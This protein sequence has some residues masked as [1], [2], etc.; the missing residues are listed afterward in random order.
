MGSD[1][2]SR[3]TVSEWSG[4]VGQPAAVPSTVG[5]G[6]WNWEFSSLLPHLVQDKLKDTE[7]AT[8]IV[9]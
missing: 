7:N 2:I 1:A 5:L 3:S 6:Y 8:L 9:R 4:I